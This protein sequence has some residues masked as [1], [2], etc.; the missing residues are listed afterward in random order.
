MRGPCSGCWLL[1]N[2]SCNVITLLLRNFC[3]PKV[4]KETRTDAFPLKLPEKRKTFPDTHAYQSLRKVSSIAA[5]IHPFFYQLFIR[6]DLC[7]LG[8]ARY[9][10][11]HYTLANNSSNAEILNIKVQKSKEPLQKFN[12]L[13]Y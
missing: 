8:K 5:E 7:G 1:S 4:L 12:M 9:P 2:N 10:T 3:S 11:M 6:C 13:S